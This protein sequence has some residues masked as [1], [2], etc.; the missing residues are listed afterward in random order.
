VRR[1]AVDSY[2]HDACGS[3]INQGFPQVPL[4]KHETPVH[5]GDAGFVAAVFYAFPDSLKDPQGMEYLGREL[6]KMKRVCKTKYISVEDELGPHAGAEGVAIHPH[7]AGER[8][9]VWVQGRRGVVGLHLEDEVIILIEPD[10][11]CIV[12]EDAHA[13]VFFRGILAYL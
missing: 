2:G 1:P 8:A 4:I 13:E 10:N 9:S 5:R 6:T 7:D 3:A 12:G 11:A